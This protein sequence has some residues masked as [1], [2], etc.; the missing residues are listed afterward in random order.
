MQKSKATSL[1]ASSR[2]LDGAVDRGKS[3]PIPQAKTTSDGRPAARAYLSRPPMGGRRVLLLRKDGGSKEESFAECEQL[4]FFYGI[5]GGARRRVVGGGERTEESTAPG[6]K[7]R[8]GW[9]PG[10]FFPC[11]AHARRDAFLQ[12]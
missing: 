6:F 12:P 4:R 2:P 8:V 7:G 1:N 3:E 9:V 11:L 5:T 10:F